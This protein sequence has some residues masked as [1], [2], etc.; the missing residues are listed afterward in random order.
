MHSQ[1]TEGNPS[2]C[3]DFREDYF[4]CLHHRKEV[5]ADCWMYIW[6]QQQHI[7]LTCCGGYASVPSRWQDQGGTWTDSERFTSCPS[8][9]SWSWRALAARWS[10]RSFTASI[11]CPWDQLILNIL[12]S[13]TLYSCFRVPKQILIR[14]MCW[15]H[16][17]AQQS[18]G[19][20]IFPVRSIVQ[21]I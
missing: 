10:S 18:L 17:P 13:Q 16:S 7:M 2:K 12:K 19:H 1:E 9:R 20:S 14:L 6:S 11:S 4:E 15:S 3:T 5:T 21:R 8:R